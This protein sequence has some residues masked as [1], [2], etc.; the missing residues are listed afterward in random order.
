MFRLEIGIRPDFGISQV[1]FG[2]EDGLRV[3]E[4]FRYLSWIVR[5]DFS[6]YVDNRSLGY[7]QY[8]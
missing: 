2:N 6:I 4:R 5:L 1:N 8:L 7:F 3:Q